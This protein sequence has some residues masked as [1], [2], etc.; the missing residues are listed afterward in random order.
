MAGLPTPTGA[1][2]LPNLTSPSQTTRAQAVANYV[3]II[4]ADYGAKWGKSLQ[5]WFNAHPSES[6]NA[7]LNAWG[8]AVAADLG[9]GLANTISQAIS[10]TG[11]L[12]AEAGAGTVAGLD[13]TEQTFFGGFLGFL[14]DLTSRAFWLR[15]AKVV[16]GL[17]LVVV[18]LVQLTHAQKLVESVGE[19]AAIA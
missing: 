6:A 8:N 1:S 12:T 14:K 5:D 18:G 10:D 16:G 2:P 4:T 7:A 19:A 17:A 13:A 11:Q 9:P 15:A 3:A